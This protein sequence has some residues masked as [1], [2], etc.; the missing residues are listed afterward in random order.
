VAPELARSA[1]AVDEAVFSRLVADLGAEH[2]EEV[3]RVFLENAAVG[4][5]AVR[6]ALDAGDARGAAEAAH[7]LKSASG[8]LG[9]GRLAGLS[10]AIEAGTAAGNVGGALVEELRRTSDELQVLVSRV[11]GAPGTS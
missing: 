1:H 3:C 4:I 11:A 7:G 8:F 6:R 2:I 10:A 5:A 9:A